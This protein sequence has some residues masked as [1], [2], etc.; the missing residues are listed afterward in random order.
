MNR[1]NLL[2]LSIII[3]LVLL[4]IVIVF[5]VYSINNINLPQKNKNLDEINPINFK[6]FISPGNEFTLLFPENWNQGFDEEGT[7]M[8]YKNKGLGTLRITLLN[9][10]SDTI[11][12]S[13]FEEQSYK[14]KNSLIYTE[15]SKYVMEYIDEPIEDNKPL[16]MHWWFIGK[17]HH[18][19]LVSFTLPKDSSN[20]S[21][22]ILELNEAKKIA[23]SIEL[24]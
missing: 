15:N 3:I 6:K 24:N 1:R 5:L 21:G 9:T 4:L 2:I 17:G 10:T 22:A 16:L 18:L 12:K 7:L 14:F 19:L 20:T 23:N 13:Y 8:L 11:S